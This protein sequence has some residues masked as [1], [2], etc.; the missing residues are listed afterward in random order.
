MDVSGGSGQPRS[1]NDE[2]AE[3]R[4]HPTAPAPGPDDTAQPEPTGPTAADP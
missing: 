1:G 4:A 2:P 3:P